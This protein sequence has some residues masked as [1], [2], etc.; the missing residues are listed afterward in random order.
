MTETSQPTQSAAAPRFG[1]LAGDAL[2]Y[3]EPR[4]L[5]Y[6]G[7]LASVVLVHFIAA[8]PT[9]RAFLAWDSLLGL[10]LLVVL[11]NVAYCAAYVVD[12]FVQMS[13]LRATW[14]RWRWALL[15]VGLAFAAVL[16]HFFSGTMFM[17]PGGD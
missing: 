2:R 4:R 15:V 9:S 16:T 6:N 10:F 14:V 5:L 17:H 3:W 1:Q 11:A 8:W 13:V 12:L 7:V